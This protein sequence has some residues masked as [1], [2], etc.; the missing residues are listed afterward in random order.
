[1]IQSNA[2]NG[3]TILEGTP[4]NMVQEATNIF[5][6][7]LKETPEI[8]L[9]VFL[10]YVDEIEKLECEDYGDK[11]DVLKFFANIAKKKFKEG[12]KYVN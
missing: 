12:K 6:G 8:L 5:G 4:I 9:A 11:L 7:M 10:T 3:I 2:K 1:M